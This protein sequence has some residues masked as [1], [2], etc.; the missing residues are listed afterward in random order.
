KLAQQEQVSLYMLLFTAYAHFL[1]QISGQQDLIVGTPVTGRQQEAFEDIQGFFVNTVA[2]R[3]QTDGVSTMEEFC[4]EVK[5][6]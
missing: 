3:V 5:E 2:I 6:R 1:Q 4:A